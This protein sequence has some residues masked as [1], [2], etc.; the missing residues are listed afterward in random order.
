MELFAL[1]TAICEITEWALPYGPIE[2][3]E[4]Q[5]KLQQGE[6]PHVSED[7]PV[8]DVIQKL[9]RFEYGS[10]QE[11]ADALKWSLATRLS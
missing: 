9:W 4:L 1:G 2:V 6:Y 8:R 3:D 7:S 5:Q 11:V 10:A